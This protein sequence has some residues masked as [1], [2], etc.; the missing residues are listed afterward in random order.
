MSKTKINILANYVGSAWSAAA[1]IVF[2]PVYISYLGIESYGLVGVFTSIQVWLSVADLGLT[3]T[4]TREMARFRAGARDRQWANNFTYTLESFI[5]TLAAFVSIVI[6]CL[7]GWIS[8][9]WLHPQN[10]DKASVEIAVILIGIAASLRWLAN[11]YRGGLMGLQNQV[12]LNVVS[13]AMVTVRSA[14]VIPVLMFV[15]SDIRAFFAF[16]VIIG[17]IEVFVLR[18][19]LKS[20]ITRPG[21]CPRFDANT[22]LEGGRFAIGL[23]IISALGACLTQVDKLIISRTLALSD[24]GAYS[25]ATTIASALLLI[26]SPVFNAL[27]PRLAQLAVSGSQDNLI[28]TYNKASQLVNCIAVAVAGMLVYFGHDV[29]GL[30]TANWSLVESI[31]PYLYLLVCGSMFFAITH[32]PY[33]LQLAYGWTRLSVIINLAALVCMVPALLKF[34]PQYG[35]TSAAVMWL[36]LNFTYVAIQIPIVHRKLG[37][38]SN[39]RWY[40]DNLLLPLVVVVIYFSFIK[41]ILTPD[42]VGMGKLREAVTLFAIETCAFFAAALSTSYGRKI[43]VGRISS[44]CA[45]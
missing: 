19:K 27:Y 5:F 8:N 18:Y 17:V 42:L 21:I 12:W 4:L 13:V 11:M 9:Y 37:F 23:A 24:F 43:L 36:I 40:L 38:I 41:Y 22:L 28:S 31:T 14:G 16:N 29:V 3:P 6:A 2:V 10:L 39:A 44:M 26:V 20:E 25:F 32:V 45:A 34:V 33:A 35:A 1:Q 7:A 30:W 15:T